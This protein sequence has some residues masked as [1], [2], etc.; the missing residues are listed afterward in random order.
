MTSSIVSSGITNALTGAVDQNKS[1]RFRTV[2]KQGQ[3]TI[4]SSDITSGN[5]IIFDSVE[6]N[7]IPISIKIWNTDLDSNSTPT[8]AYSAGVFK[9][10]VDGTYS[11]NNTGDDAIFA[12]SGQTDLQAANTS[13]VDVVDIAGNFRRAAKIGNRIAD[14]A[15]TTNAQPSHFYV[16]L[17]ITAS[18]A[19]GASGTIGYEITSAVSN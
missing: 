12:A 6:A 11:I 15:G 8:A 5:Y 14:V 16:G 18:A 13:G 4:G 19:T 2:V 10:K 3:I 1:N 9:R 17:K 7:A